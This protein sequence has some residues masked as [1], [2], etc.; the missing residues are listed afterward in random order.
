MLLFDV[1]FILLL[2]Y[3]YIFYLFTL[4]SDSGFLVIKRLISSIM[5][6]EVSIK[7]KINVEDDK[8]ENPSLMLFESYGG[9]S[10]DV[11]IALKQLII[12]L[13]P[14]SLHQSVP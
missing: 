5:N 4:L 8:Y 7:I 10:P 1:F 3:N 6:K 9:V 13:F 2:K 12:F 14:L 11:G